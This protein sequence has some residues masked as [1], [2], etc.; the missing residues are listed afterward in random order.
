MH[1]DTYNGA[2]VD[3]GGVA[4]RE[5]DV[6]IAGA[7]TVSRSE[8]T[9]GHVTSD[10]ERMYY[11]RVLPLGD[12]AWTIEF[13]DRID[14]EV[15]ARVM[16]LADSL[17][18]A[19]RAADWAVLKGVVDIVPAFRS[20]TVHFDPLMTDAAELERCLEGFAGAA[21]GVARAGRCWR[22]PVCFEEELAPDLGRVAD[23]TGLSAGTV[24]SLMTST[25]FRVYMIGFMPG[26]PYMGG[27]PEALEMPRLAS[28]RKRVPARSLAIAGAMCAVYPSESPGGWNLIGRLPLPLFASRAEPPA[29]LAAGDLVEWQAIDRACFRELEQRSRIGA[30]DPSSFLVGGAAS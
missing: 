2:A 14:L 13:G 17:A 12:C 21:R 25:R 27:L 10:R 28:P 19:C 7:V 8:A 9:G 18:Q 29:L 30:L 20:L 5:P 23:T 6:W 15:N 16:A 26:F 3:V 11:P 22:L 24:R 4:F 1:V